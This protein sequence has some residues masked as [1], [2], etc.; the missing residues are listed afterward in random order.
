MYVVVRAVPMM[1]V[2]ACVPYVVTC[3]SCA[4][5]CGARRDVS[6][7]RCDVGHTAGADDSDAVGTKKKRHH[8]HQREEPGKVPLVVVPPLARDILDIQPGEGGIVDLLAPWSQT[9]DVLSSSMR[10]HRK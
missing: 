1:M 4:R 7:A 5:V 9:S 2:V 8:Y 6:H 10:G 3:V